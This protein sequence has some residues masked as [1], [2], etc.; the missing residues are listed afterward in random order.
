MKEEEYIKLIFGLK[1]KQ[2]RTDRGLSLFKLS[3]ITGMSK[4][5]LNEI[6]KGKKY[7]KTNKIITLS[8]ALEVPYDELVSLKL[9]KNLAPIAEILQSNIL[10]EIPLDLF[11][12]EERDLIDIISEAPAKVNA[13]I[14]TL[15]EIGVNYNLTRENFFL[16]A[17]R[18]YQEANDNYF[19]DLE[20]KS[21]AFT[22]AYKMNSEEEIDADFLSEILKE[23]FGYNIVFEDFSFHDKIL[24]EL[25]TIFFPEK[26]LLLINKSTAPTEIAFIYAKEIGYNYLELKDRTLTFSWSKFENFDQILNNFY[27]SYFA[28]CV[29]LPQ[30]SIIEDLK[31]IFA[32]EEWSADLFENLIKKHNCSAETFYQRLTNLL[33]KHFNIRDLFFIRLRNRKGS[34]YFQLTKELHLSKKQS[35]HANETLEHYCRRWVSVN[36]IQDLQK[37]QKKEIITD[38]QYSVY[39]NEGNSK[40]WVISSATLDPFKEDNY[41]SVT[42]GLSMPNSARKIQFINKEDGLKE[43]EVAVTCENC[44]IKDCKERVAEPTRYLKMKRSKSMEDAIFLLKAKQNEVIST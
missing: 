32:Q 37:H 38:A 1:I 23:E 26:K 33:P 12:I 39:P 20:E 24:K 35:P 28:A 22:Q 43:L 30:K 40:Y 44:A 18:S 13:F 17:L 27:A 36:V 14:S 8:E 16:A 19:E 41:R 34:E 6:E 3:K 9:D 15:I 7:P 29:L 25:R 4:S 5:Y 42:L 2:I 10:K 21:E 31:S 11:G